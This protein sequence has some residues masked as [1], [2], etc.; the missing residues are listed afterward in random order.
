MSMSQ[1]EIEELLSQTEDFKDSVSST[2]SEFEFDSLNDSKIVDSNEIENL[3]SEIESVSPL[4]EL[5][6]EDHTPVE[7]KKVETMT[8][9][10]EDEIVKNWTASKIDEGIFP[11]PAEKD[12]KV[13]NQL[14]QVANDSE[15][16]V[17]QIFDVLSLT[18]DNNSAIRNKL[19]KSDEFINSQVNLLNSL[20]FFIKWF[21]S[22]F[23]NV[24]KC[25]IIIANLIN[26]KE[27]EGLSL[28]TSSKLSLSCLWL[29]EFATFFIKPKDVIDAI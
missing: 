20:S 21:I 13:V 18:L 1:E 9:K 15:E 28:T 26:L 3:L 24:P 25:S 7:S 2:H 27:F 22:S 14:S 19:K 5:V 6:V 23:G 11:L 17:S 10:S 8:Q 12:T 4:K 16:K 29:T